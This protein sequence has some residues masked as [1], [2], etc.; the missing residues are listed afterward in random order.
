MTNTPLFTDTSTAG[1]DHSCHDATLRLAAAW[2]LDV[3]DPAS[4]LV[5]C[6]GSCRISGFESDHTVGSG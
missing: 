6:Q 5:L 3:R 1:Y 2:N 4:Q